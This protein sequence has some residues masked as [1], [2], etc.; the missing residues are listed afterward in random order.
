MELLGFIDGGAG[1]VGQIGGGIGAILIIVGGLNAFFGYKIFKI[2]IT[3]ISFIIGM[4]VGVVLFGAM[5][6][7]I[8]FGIILGLAFGVGCAV[9]AVKFYF[10]AVFLYCGLWGG[11][12]G[13]LLSDGNYAV[14]L[15]LFVIVGFVGAYL[16]RHVIIL[17][18][19]LGG[20]A[21]LGIGLGLL[22]GVSGIGVYI[23]LIFLAF[24]A[25]A[26]VQ[27]KTN[28]NT[29]V[30]TVQNSQADST[31]YTP[32]QPIMPVAKSLFCPH[33]GQKTQG[34]ATFCPACGGKS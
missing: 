10:F 5:A 11:V 22:L 32:P 31:P 13:F 2:L 21:A 9:L 6:G 30:S 33:C 12:L 28:A 1:L 25:G 27:Y 19:A 3:V 14:A 17:S 24:V 18:S 23:F 8:G 16:E 15:I 26:I 7:S 29:V 4:A 20:G 34:A